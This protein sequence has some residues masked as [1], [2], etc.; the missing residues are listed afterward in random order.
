MQLNEAIWGDSTHQVSQTS[1]Y[2][3]HITV[4]DIIPDIYTYYTSKGM[5]EPIDNS[6]AMW[7]IGDGSWFN[8]QL[9]LRR[10]GNDVIQQDERTTVNAKSLWVCVAGTFNTANQI[11]FNPSQYQC[12]LW[13]ADSTSGYYNNSSVAG[14]RGIITGFDYN[15]LVL[16]NRLCCRLYDSQTGIHSGSIRFFSV[17]DYFFGK[18]NDDVPY[19]DLYCIEAITVTI[20]SS[21]GA[22]PPSPA[23]PYTVSNVIPLNNPNSMSYGGRFY[24]NTKY[25]TPVTSNNYYKPDYLYYAQANDVIGLQRNQRT[26]IP[27]QATFADNTSFYVD[28]F[29]SGKWAWDEFRESGTNYVATRYLGTYDEIMEQLAY[30]GLWFSETDNYGNTE[31]MVTG[32]D[33]TDEHVCL[34]EI[35]N[36]RTTGKFKRGVEAGAD[37]QAQWG[38]Q[39]R[40]N[41]GYNGDKPYKNEDPNTYDEDQTTI[42]RQPLYAQVGG[43]TYITTGTYF[44]GAWNT[45]QGDILAALDDLQDA[46]DDLVVA[47]DNWSGTAVEPPEVVKARA[48]VEASEVI[49]EKQKK[50]RSGLHTNPVDCVKSILAF[51]F[52]LRTYIA[53][54]PSRSMVWGLYPVY[55]YGEPLVP[56]NLVE[57][58]T[59][60]FWVPGGECT[61]FAEYENFL[62]YSPY[63]SAE[64]YI[65]YCGS[66][67]I[68][69]ETFIGHKLTVRYLVDWHTGACLALVYRDNLVVEQISGQMAVSIPMAAAD[70]MSYANSLFQGQQAVKNAQTAAV[71]TTASGL[72]QGFTSGMKVAVAPTAGNI[73]AGL[74]SIV[75]NAAAINLA[76]NNVKS[77]EYEL[78][79][80]QLSYKQV[81]TAT[82]MTSTANEQECRLVLY[83]PTFLEG[84]NKDDFGTY[85]HT[86]GFA[87]L[88]N[89]SLAEFSGLT[90]CSSADL[91]G[92]G[93]ATEAE[94]ALIDKAL[95]TGVYL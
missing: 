22:T 47:L 10:D 72:V 6:I 26:S 66:V 34:P 90:V 49:L 68:D 2:A 12:N 76:Q 21:N 23:T 42:L 11:H 55:P 82:P 73:G 41:V 9:F 28:G 1:P 25:N 75:N 92:I 87:C 62:D 52:D 32:P 85:G 71:A 20:G 53:S 43:H 40:D 4:S 30:F 37:P 77:A 7:Q 78:A 36:G 93:R 15:R 81:T 80:K 86:T 65:P 91:S 46:S 27:Q 19:K 88:E 3:N 60:Q 38:N 16:R 69:P 29:E 44:T 67:N 56:Y 95:R 45:V 5:S 94:K 17:Y 64:L 50:K 18:N 8:K 59:S 58:T 70:S 57:G 83:R 89:K 61:Y 14:K 39:W 33:C 35:L 63:C 31:V 84:Y 74:S 54:T 51:P 24:T 48:V 13:D 79:T